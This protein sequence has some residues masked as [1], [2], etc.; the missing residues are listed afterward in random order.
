MTNECTNCCEEIE[1]GKEVYDD[2][3]NV[4]CCLNH[5]ERFHNNEIK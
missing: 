2:E 4:F 5:L 3:G 1:E